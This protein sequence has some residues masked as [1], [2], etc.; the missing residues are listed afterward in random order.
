MSVILYKHYAHWTQT[1]EHGNSEN[2]TAPG[3]LID[4]KDIEIKW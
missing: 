1:A 2:S 3:L 4:D